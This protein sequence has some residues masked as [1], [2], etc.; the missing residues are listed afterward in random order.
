MRAIDCGF[1]QKVCPIVHPQKVCLFVWGG[2]GK[3]GWGV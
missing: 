1:A 2:V 3:V